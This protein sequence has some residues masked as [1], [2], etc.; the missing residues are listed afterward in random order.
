MPT[1][2]LL[3]CFAFFLWRY[4]EEKEYK[5]AQKALRRQSRQRRRR[6]DFRRK[7]VGEAM[8]ERE[9]EM[10][11]DLR[12]SQLDGM[13]DAAAYRQVRGLLYRGGGGRGRRRVLREPF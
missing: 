6:S 7:E 2:N 4:Q 5:D 3:S 10:K 11:A 8:K 9:E 13:K 1:I 12:A